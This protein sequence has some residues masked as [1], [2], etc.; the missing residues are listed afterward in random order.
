MPIGGGN[1][2]THDRAGAVWRIATVKVSAM[3][4]CH[5]AAK[6]L[7]IR[8]SPASSRP[9]TTAASGSGPRGS[10]H[11]APS[12]AGGYPGPAREPAEPGRAGRA[13][14]LRARPANTATS[15]KVTERRQLPRNPEEP[16]KCYRAGVVC[17]G[18]S[19]RCLLGWSL[20]WQDR[21]AQ[22]TPIGVAWSGP[23]RGDS[24]FW[25]QPEV[26][27]A[28]GVFPAGWGAEPASGL[29]SRYLIS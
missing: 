28:V 1:E 16:R 19:W 29:S 5:R 14:P 17:I 6:P 23:G 21:R 18:W 20:V 12:A 27:F 4:D 15:P 11:W 13:R 2:C 24:G 10:G 9:A 8:E 3:R 22:A 26:P 7:P 25:C